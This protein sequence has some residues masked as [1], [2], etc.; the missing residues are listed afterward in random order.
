MKSFST[1]RTILPNLLILFISLLLSSVTIAAPRNFAELCQISASTETAKFSKFDT[2]A[3]RAHLQNLANQK[4]PTYG[5]EIGVELTAEKLSTE[6]IRKFW[7]EKG[8]INWAWGTVVDRPHIFLSTFM[9]EKDV[10]AEMVA[11]RDPR[12]KYGIEQWHDHK[13]AQG[14]LRATP[15]TGKRRWQHNFETWKTRHIAGAKNSDMHIQRTYRWGKWLW[16]SVGLHKLFFRG[17]GNFRVSFPLFSRSRLYDNRMT[18]EQL[19]NLESALDGL[20]KIGMIKVPEGQRELWD[21]KKSHWSRLGSGAREYKVIEDGVEKTFY[22]IIYSYPHAK[23]LDEAFRQVSEWANTQ[24]EKTLRGDTD[25]LDPITIAGA[26]KYAE[27]FF[28]FGIN[29]NGRS[30]TYL[31]NLVLHTFNLPMDV[32]FGR[33]DWHDLDKGL[34]GYIDSVRLGVFYMAHAS[35]NIV[36]DRL[37]APDM[38]KIGLETGNHDKTGT[39]SKAE[40]KLIAPKSIPKSNDQIFKMGTDFR[41]NFIFKDHF[42]QGEQ[43]VFYTYHNGKMYPLS[44]Y[45]VGL[46]A[47]GGKLLQKQTTANLYNL[48]ER[49][50]AFE[51]A[52]NENIALFKRLVKERDFGHEVEIVQYKEIAEF[53]KDNNGIGS[54]HLWEFQKDVVR[55]ALAMFDKESEF[56]IDP[57]RFPYATLAL[58]RGD[59]LSPKKSGPTVFQNMFSSGRTN[60]MHPSDVLSAYTRRKAELVKLKMDL[61]QNHRDLYEELLPLLEKA[62]EHAYIAARRLLKEG[63]YIQFVEEAYGVEPGQASHPELISKPE[64]HRALQ[65]SKVAE[66]L[67][68]QMK[69]SEWYYESYAQ[70]KKEINEN[71]VYVIR[72]IGI[73]NFK[74]LGLVTEKQQAEILS[75]LKDLARQVDAEIKRANKE[76][77]GKVQVENIQG[78]ISRRVASFASEFD[79]DGIQKERTGNW[80]FRST[81]GEKNKRRTLREALNKAANGIFVDYYSTRGMDPEF[82]RSFFDFYLH[83]VGEHPQ[84][85]KST[86]A[87][88][89]YEYELNGKGELKFAPGGMSIAYKSKIGKEGVDAR[90]SP[91][92]G[93]EEIAEKQRFGGYWYFSMSRLKFIIEGREQFRATEEELALKT[94]RYRYEELADLEKKELDR[95]KSFMEKHPEYQMSKEEKQTY[96]TES[97]ELKAK[98]K[99]QD[100]DGEKAELMLEHLRLYLDQEIQ[101]VPEGTPIINSRGDIIN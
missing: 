26:L 35:A 84:I 79:A 69:N 25:A 34:E 7:L 100:K 71:Y 95:L 86:S 15:V 10:T 50:P 2:M 20:I 97:R 67:M 9:N 22:D 70:A 3:T 81:Q 18:K 54:L 41:K 90:D 4:N 40:R 77:D 83:T 49:T 16:H 91:Y 19:E 76:D 65:N 47:Q 13:Q 51:K 57:Y 88:P 94:H 29:G 75:F 101:I 87:N 89:F 38:A 93:Q 21:I 55:D 61:K 32:R 59:H 45:V 74:F 98:Y 8:K 27:V 44:D 96:F 68:A 72:N 85:Y 62:D 58:N 60:E 73:G 30:T 52:R 66:G 28:H 42:W 63:K 33:D 56:Y 23:I 82:D 11:G 99:Q 78:F 14:L 6:S 92:I 1:K 17:G 31:K 37:P 48:R 43:G 39:Y 53:N 36:N 24:I 5:K 80:W 12:L 64:A 46:Y